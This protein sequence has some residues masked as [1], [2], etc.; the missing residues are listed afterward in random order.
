VRGRH[1]ALDV[2]AHLRRQGE[3]ERIAGLT[4]G[5]TVL[6]QHNAGTTGAFMGP[7]T[8]MAATAESA[9]RA[10]C[11]DARSPASSPGCAPT[12]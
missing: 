12:T 9:R 7:N 10:T 6:D 2:V 3:Q 11:P 8:A 5:V 4:L 1:R